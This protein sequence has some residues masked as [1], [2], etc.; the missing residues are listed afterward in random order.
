MAK[1]SKIKVIDDIN[2]VVTRIKIPTHKWPGN[3]MW[4]ATECYHAGL[5]PKRSLVCYG[6][7]YGF[8]HEE[9]RF[10]D[11]PFTHHAWIELPDRSIYDPTQ[12]AF[13]CRKPHIYLGP[14]RPDIYDL[15]SSSQWEHLPAPGVT[16]PSPFKLAKPKV[17]KLKRFFRSLQPDGPDRGQ[18]H[19]LAHRHPDKLGKDAK[20][21]YQAMIQNKMAG[22]I[23]VDFKRYVLR[24][25]PER[26]EVKVNSA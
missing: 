15:G 6:M 24:I 10:A 11:R 2:E 18:W 8:I 13:T 3:C 25:N 16:T 7:Y 21:I 14:P 20:W 1:T 9:S 4:I 26:S 22:M 12:W 17:S 23:P 19:W 5:V